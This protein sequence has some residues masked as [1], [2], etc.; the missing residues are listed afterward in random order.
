MGEPLRVGIVGIGSIS[1]TYLRTLAR[2]P[3]VRVTRLADLGPARAEAALQHAP[4]ARAV[5]ADELMKSADV[6][7]VLNLTTPAAHAQIAQAALAAGKHLYGEKPLAL[8]LDQARGVLAQAAACGSA[9]RRTPRSAPE[10]RPR[11]G[12]SRT[13]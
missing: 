12:P 8:D 5:S 3:Q 4:G 6:D 9:T 13:V 1:G 7:L 2:L 10:P 11:A